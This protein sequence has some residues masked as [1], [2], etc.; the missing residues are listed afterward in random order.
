MTDEQWRIVQQAIFNGEQS[1]GNYQEYNPD[2]GA[3]GAY[4]FIPETW[5]EKANLYGYGAYAD[6]P[7]ASY[8]PPDIQDSVARAWA[9]DLLNRYNGDIRYVVSAWLGGEGAADEDYANGYISTTRSDGNITSAE[10]VDRALSGLEAQPT[11]TTLDTNY[12]V[13]NNPDQN[14]TNTERLRPE[15][16]WGANMLGAWLYS[17][18]QVPLMITGGAEIGYHA[19]SASGHGHE[20]GWKIDVANDEIAGGT[21]G[22]VLFKEF[23]NNQGW[24]CNWE[25]DHWD[26]DFSGTDSRDPQKGGF[27]GNFF[28]EAFRSMPDEY[29]YDYINQMMN[30]PH[31]E[32]ENVRVNAVN[33]VLTPSFWDTVSLAGTAFWQGM[34]NDTGVGNLAQ[35]LWSNVFHSSNHFGKPSDL[36]AQDIEYVKNILPDDE[37]A[38]RFILL[39][40]RDSEEAKYL[41]NQKLK[42]KQRDEAIAK[43]N[44]G[45]TF[46]IVNAARFAGGM[47]DPTMLIPVGAA[48]NGLKIAGRLGKAIYD[49]SKVAKIATRAAKVG[50]VNS[51]MSVADN[52]LREKYGGYKPDYGWDAAV[53]G[54]AG[55]VLGGLGGLFGRNASKSVT[56]DIISKADEVET[57]AIYHAADMKMPTTDN[58]RS[59]TINKARAL[60]DSEFG[61]SIK[62]KFYSKLEAN[63]RIVAMPY[64][65][66]RKL[67]SEASGIDIPKAAK[68]FY[69]P[70]EDYAIILTDNIKG[71]NID[72][73]LAHEFGV[74]AG[75][76]P[77]I[78]EK[79]WTRLTDFVSREAN[80]PDTIWAQARRMSGE[81]DPEEIIAYAIENNLIS[82]TF[83][84]RV[85]GALNKAF[86]RE[87]INMRVTR[88]Q[89]VDLLGKQM[90]AK[91]NVIN[92]IHYNEDGST[93]FAG[94]RFSKDNT[95]NPQRWADFIELEQNVRADSQADMPKWMPKKVSQW[96]EDGILFGNPYGTG[97]NS[98]SNTMRAITSRLLDDPRG[99]GRGTISPLSAERQKERVRRILAKPY[100][101]F[102][103]CRQ[104]YILKNK[105]LPTRGAHLAYD[106]QVIDY[107][108]AMFEKGSNRANVSL[109]VPDE[110]KQGAQA[111]MRLREKQIEISKRSAI[112]MGI[113]NVNNL[114]EADWKPVDPEI[115]RVIDLDKRQQFL[116]SFNDEMGVEAEDF[117]SDYMRRAAK[118][119]VIKARIERDIDKQNRK[120]QQA[121]DKIPKGSERKPEPLLD[122]NVTDK[123]INKWLDEHIPNAVKHWIDGNYDT[124][125]KTDKVGDVGTLS[126][127]KTRIPLDTTITVEMPNGRQFS[128]DNNLRSYDLDSIIT[129]NINRFA[130]E[131]AIK[132]TFGNQKGLEATLRKT[133]QEL[134]IAVKAGRIN[135]SRA[136]KEYRLLEENIDEIRGFRP[137]EE[138][139]G[140]FGALTRIMSK[141][142]YAYNGTNMGF[143]QLGELGGTM[144]YGGVAQLAHI[145]RPLGEIIDN[146]RF[147]K[148]TNEALHEAQDFMFGAELE[149]Q[150][151]T[152]TWEDNVIRDALTA[153]N[154]TNKAI[155]MAGTASTALSQV[156]SALN[157]LPKM[158]D[159]MLRGM[160]NQTLMDSIRWA[161]GKTFSKIR[162]PFSEAKLKASHISPDEAQI[163]K[164]NIKKYTTIK[165]GNVVKFDVSKWQMENSK[166][167]AQ[168]YCLIDNQAKRAIVSAGQ[169]GNR[170]N[171]KNMNHF[172]RL[173]FQFKDYSFRAV[174]AQT[175]RAMT[176]GDLDDAIA[177]MSSIVTNT[178]A[179]AIKA[180]A[181]YTAL[182]ATGATDKAQDYYDRMF[183]DENLI[184][185]AAFR[186]SIVGSPFS[187]VNDLGEMS[188]LGAFANGSIRTT[189]SRNTYGQPKDISDIPGRVVSQIPS[190]Q[191]VDT[192]ANVPA[193]IWNSFN[194]DNSKKDFK[195]FI[196]AFPYMKWLPI[197][198][199]VNS[200]IDNSNYPDK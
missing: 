79:E 159:S 174:N 50:I 74:H 200:I 139:M 9:D 64:E 176:A 181:T 191:T 76:K 47:L 28:G 122:K 142:T 149:S 155:N 193:F 188:G 63:N 22:G 19:K 58:I 70:N 179:Y 112:D 82:D 173:L 127:L 21:E 71:A 73:I 10:Y 162:N 152:K 194:D 170:N 77:L 102:M 140:R 186:S 87:G 32:L 134:D 52:A 16:I 151:F 120:I 80:K 49:T 41:A 11:A 92:Q 133:K 137:R 66:A 94:I 31:D 132:N 23:C 196:E 171:L 182:Q 72:S 34:T 20:D 105:K 119:D 130:G 172:T 136:D 150:I 168:F 86:N 197:N 89:V 55:A 163:I 156:T 30:A 153:D 62:S 98:V 7:N 15:S 109:D 8:A 158:T 110:V 46:T 115:W 93:A 195:K 90:D 190:L 114:I 95:F 154:I 33:D 60:H 129:R 101:D 185:A 1:Q 83:T 131:I 121:N 178:A 111:L 85:K 107:Y 118:R 65:K 91:R 27:T 166:S 138:I 189:V 124:T 147:G 157:M 35:A 69:V 4:Q 57:K 199:V 116:N 126:T 3:A 106:K 12:I 187:L 144:A 43:Y 78:G 145:F 143:A 184:R 164:D 38:Q 36:T 167:F 26:I 165:N 68:A 53:A 75:L 18:Y 146:A 135:K 125:A 6:I 42:D 56:R 88:E 103:N 24:S 54:F 39:N 45:C 161:N 198:A 108:N 160:R 117:L 100:I 128:F 180:G 192:L 183:S 61:K 59:E 177:A 25:G 123:D 148:M 84:S 175:M 48:F 141:L 169:I 44:D 40:A 81:Y 17:N 51:G 96:L 67:V 13:T 29:G 97:I 104:Q 113:P 37:E 14:V 2:S 5:R 99:R